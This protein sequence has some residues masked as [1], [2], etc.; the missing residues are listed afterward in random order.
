MPGP[1]SEGNRG[2]DCSFWIAFWTAWG[3][4]ISKLALFPPC[5]DKFK[6]EMIQILQL[7]DEVP[8]TLSNG[9]FMQTVYL[10]QHQYM[11][12]LS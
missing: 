11:E 2:R 3:N 5:L 10:C 12:Y 1:G 9:H 7:S 8:G 6:V 4:A